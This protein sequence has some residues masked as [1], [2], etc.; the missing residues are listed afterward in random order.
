MVELGRASQLLVAADELAT[1]VVVIDAS[2][3]RENIALAIRIL[4]G[5]KAWRPHVKTARTPVGMSMLLDAGVRSFKASTL[6]EVACLLELGVSDVLLAFPAGRRALA[7]LEVLARVSPA[8]RLSA[9]LDDPHVD[10]W[11]TGVEAFIDIDVGMGRTGVAASDVARTV[12]IADALVRQGA[13]LRGLHSYDGHL[14][15]AE[16]RAASVAELVA[17]ITSHAEGLAQCGHVVDEMVIGSSHTLVESADWIRFQRDGPRITCGAGTVVYGDGRSVRRFERDGLDFQPA[18]VIL[19]RVLSTAGDRV[20]VDAGLTAIQVD[21]GTPH[22]E[23]VGG[24]LDVVSAS[25][26]HLVLR[27]RGRRPARGDLLAL[28]PTHLDT[29][30]SQMTEA[31]Y[32]DSGAMVSSRVVGRH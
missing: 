23:V 20:T 3:V 21:A 15:D 1:P 31:Y 27:A 32:F 30:L 25:Q 5:A 19:S 26:E 17:T 10:D 7:G 4:G 9:L 13:T 16:D 18:A 8:T 11:P 28:L 12:Q 24:G 29:A 22:A 2:V 6:G 14:A